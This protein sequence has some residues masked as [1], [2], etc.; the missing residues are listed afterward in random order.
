MARVTVA[1]IFLFIRKENKKKTQGLVMGIDT[2]RN[3]FR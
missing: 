2:N 3:Y 1:P